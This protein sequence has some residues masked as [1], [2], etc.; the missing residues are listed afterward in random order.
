MFLFNEILKYQFNHF[1]FMRLAMKEVIYNFLKQNKGKR[2]TCTELSKQLRIS[3]AT[4]L[5]WV[6][7]LSA[8]KKIRI[9]DYGNLKQVWVDNNE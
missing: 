6:E 3:Y 4:I 9:A 7:V 8:E 2:F 5:K 1:Y